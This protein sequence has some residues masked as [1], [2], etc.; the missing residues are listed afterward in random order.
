LT[1]G[2]WNFKN[3][4]VSIMIMRALPKA[5]IGVVL[6]ILLAVSPVAAQDTVTEANRLS[7]A[8]LEMAAEARG[9]CACGLLR[10]ALDSV[11]Q[12]VAL[13]SEAVAEAMRTDSDVLAQRVYY[14]ATNIT[15]PAIYL[16][17]EVSSYC[18]RATAEPES[19]GCFAQTGE[20]AAEADLRNNETIMAAIGAGAIPSLEVP[21]APPPQ[22]SPIPDEDYIRDHE[23]PPASPI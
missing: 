17:G 12:A 13:L 4:E 7:S 6:G 5:F 15:E 8:A 19:L 18:S 14:V 10:E 21:E 1:L 22:E 2:I 3:T 16:I 20:G 23:Q 9:G 11:N